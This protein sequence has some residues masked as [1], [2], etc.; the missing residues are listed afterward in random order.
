[1]VRSS[2]PRPKPTVRVKP[3]PALPV[4]LTARTPNVRL[5][6]DPHAH[7]VCRVCGRIQRIELT[8]LDRHLLTELAAQHPEG[9]SV[10]GVAFSLTG[11]CLRCREGPAA[12]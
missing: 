9:W 1:M 10:D 3:I 7:I 5:A 4:V 11:A 6:E 12:R 2:R 8:E